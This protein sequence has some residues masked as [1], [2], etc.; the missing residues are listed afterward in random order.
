MQRTWGDD[1]GYVLVATGRAEIMLDPIVSIWDCAALAPVLREAGGT[2]T[3]W[4]GVPTIASGE[5]LGTNGLVLAQALA[6]LNDV[7]EDPYAA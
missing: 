3:D 1:Y 2:C 6:L 4:R 5:L 7:E